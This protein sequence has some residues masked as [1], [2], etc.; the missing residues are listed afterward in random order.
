[1]ATIKKPG[2]TLAQAVGA[3]LALAALLPLNGRGEAWR[4]VFF[5]DSQDPEWGPWLNT[6]VLTELA[7]AV[8]NERPA[9]VLFGGDLANVPRLEV[10]PL[11]TNLM[12][13]VYEA[14]IPI[15]P[16]IG[17]HDEW[18]VPDWLDT[19]AA[20][21]PDN[22]P[23]GEVHLSYAI[24]HSNALIVALDA[25]NQ[26]NRFRIN[27]P[28]LSALLRTNQLTHVFAFSHP[29]AFKLVH[30]DCLG[31]YPDQRDGFWLSL[32]QAGCRVYFCGHDH[33]FDHSRVDD[34][35]GNPENDVHQYISG[36]GGSGFYPDN[37][38]NGFN[39]HWTPQRIL[40]DASHGYVLVEV[41]GDKVTVTWKRRISPGVFEAS[42]DVFSYVARPRLNVT[43]SGSHNHLH[44]PGPGVLQSAPEPWG[45]FTN[46]P[47]AFSPYRLTDFAEPRLFF[48]VVPP[49][50]E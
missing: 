37:V 27:Q 28:W 40:H 29:P 6:N 19:F 18:G 41:D 42:S 47:S 1:M 4:F 24:R 15:Y 44:W 34:G 39:S 23:E 43:L 25:F 14:G 35:D 12:W 38:Y 49:P 22:G 50:P 48:R 10:P 3:L 9:F 20:T 31:S 21:T 2:R 45:P 46:V 36:T 30:T 5:S 16:V 13:P 8:T 26:T 7:V 33:F 32:M 11:W 17:N